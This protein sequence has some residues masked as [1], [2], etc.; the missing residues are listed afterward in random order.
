MR[1]IFCW[2]L[3]VCFSSFA[4]VR[5]GVVDHDRMFEAYLAGDMSV[6]GEEIK[7]CSQASGLTVDDKLDLCNYL[8]GY[9][10]VILETEKKDVVEEWLA[11][12]EN[13]LTTVEGAGKEK[14]MTL[15]YRSSV[16]AY[17]AMLYPLK[18]IR[19]ASQSI[20]LIDDAIE[21]DSGNPIA[22]GLKGNMKFYMP[23]IAGGSKREALSLFTEA[24]GLLADACPD[25]YRWNRCGM[26]LCLAQAYEKTGD[27]DKALSVANATLERVPDYAYM[28]DV[29]LPSLSEE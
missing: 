7:R 2:I 29:F 1:Y 9:I 13:Y 25:V 4:V 14:S 26:E 28:R 23:A 11:L 24:L 12:W 19:Y 18:A 17:R 3:A 6:W 8:Y 22:I 27:K 10:A 20:K 15:V 16:S 21:A 5:A